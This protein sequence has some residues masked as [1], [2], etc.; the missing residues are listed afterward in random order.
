[1][2]LP[3]QH[4]ERTQLSQTLS[5]EVFR[6]KKI[7]CFWGGK[8]VAAVLPGAKPKEIALKIIRGIL[9]GE[10][11]TPWNISRIVVV[12]SLEKSLIDELQLCIQQLSPQSNTSDSS[13]TAQTLANAVAEICKTQ[14]RNLSSC[15]QIAL[16]ENISNC[17]E[18]HQKELGLPLAV[19][20]SIKYPHEVNKWLGSLS[21]LVNLYC[22]GDEAKIKA[23]AQKSE[24]ACVFHERFL[25]QIEQPLLH[26]HKESWWGQAS[27]PGQPDSL[28][29]CAQTKGY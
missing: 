3:P 9:E 23:V 22:F 5:L 26:G 7:Q 21:N 16:L 11:G 20:T 17:D 24:A 19:I 6:T 18:S 27:T 25:D 15:P 14:G 2:Y 29:F 13:Q 8:S 28:F 4:P 12:E 10:G 1:V